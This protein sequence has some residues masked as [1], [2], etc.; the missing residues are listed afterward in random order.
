MKGYKQTNSW[1]NVHINWIIRKEGKIW[2][3]SC[4]KKKWKGT[5]KG[6]QYNES[7]DLS[8]LDRDKMD[9]CEDRKKINRCSVTFNF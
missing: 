7:A 9:E 1:T 8:I 2:G 5:I 4:K 6:W 3:M